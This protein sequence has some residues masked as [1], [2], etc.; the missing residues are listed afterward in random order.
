LEE[1]K[2]IKSDRNFR[3]FRK[4]AVQ[5]FIGNRNHYGPSS[6]IGFNMFKA[7]KHFDTERIDY[8]WTHIAENY[9]VD[10]DDMHERFPQVY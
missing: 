1:K 10:V 9:I 7:V 2:L 4:N 8:W 5:S 3:E 6:Q